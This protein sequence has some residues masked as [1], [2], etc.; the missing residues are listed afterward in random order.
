MQ[1]VRDVASGRYEKLNKA[2]KLTAHQLTDAASK[3]K[4]SSTSILLAAPARKAEDNDDN[5]DGEYDPESI[6]S[7]NRDDDEVF[8]ITVLNLLV[9]VVQKIKDAAT[10][11]TSNNR[12]KGTNKSA[13]PSKKSSRQAIAS[14]HVM[15]KLSWNYVLST[16]K[17]E[18][19]HVEG[20]TDDDLEGLETEEDASHSSVGHKRDRQVVNDNRT[21][22][23]SEEESADDEITA[24]AAS[25]KRESIKKIREE[26]K[27][28]AGQHFTSELKRELFKLVISASD[29]ME[30]FSMLMNRDHKLTHSPDIAEVLVQ[31]CC[32]STTYN[33][34]FAKVLLRIVLSSK[35]GATTRKGKEEH[36][37]P[38][39]VG[40]KGNR[41]FKKALQYAIWDK[42]K[43]IRVGNSGRRVDIVTMVNLSCLVGFLFSE[44]IFGLALLRGLDLDDGIDRNTGLFSRILIL[45]LCCEL[46]PTQL[47]SLFFGGSISSGVSQV[48][49]GDSGLIAHDINIDTKPLRKAMRKFLAVYFLDDN[50]SKKWIPL[51]IDV[52]SF[53][54][55][56]D[57]SHSK[58]NTTGVQSR[59]LTTLPVR[60]K[61]IDKALREGI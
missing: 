54:T 24:T 13:G 34:Y 30:C 48:G 10:G 29:D 8:T 52:V 60:F 1:L 16:L 47:T 46:E 45:R 22:E 11:V 23:E 51:F 37:G 53:G 7:K 42:F 19:W 26:E 38:G 20:G 25:I 59:P 4:V 15:P 32:Q 3:A 41:V 61:L 39:A 35:K 40:V 2:K 27:A 28:L 36:E 50:E 31:C 12:K 17:D 6:S 57:T 43:Q 14:L 18:Q 56:Y 55:Q 44:D 21:S 49:D 33:P 5:E 9:S 58:N